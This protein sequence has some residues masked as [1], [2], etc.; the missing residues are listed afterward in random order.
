MKTFCKMWTGKV[1][2]TTM[3]LAFGVCVSGAA[4]A[5]PFTFEFD[6]PDWT[7]A[8]SIA[9][10]GSNPIVDITVD[11]GSSSDLN[12]TYHNS[13]ITQIVVKGNGGSFDGSWAAPNSGG[14]YVY[15]STNASGAAVLDL[16]PAS[17]STEAQFFNSGD[18]LT[19]QLA[20]TSPSGG[21]ESLSILAGDYSIYAFDSPVSPNGGPN[22]GID[23]S[24]QL[25][26]PAGQSGGQQVPEPWSAL[27]IG[28]G[29]AGL[30][31]VR[32]RS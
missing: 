12:Q 32:R 26:P 22:V 8:S 29:L 6:L 10:F 14:N 11:N 18:D 7:A 2:A 1:L 24:G 15:V 21:P 31:V 5:T 9:L 13:Q 25:V 16:A 30:A 20:V 28:I 19:L 17:T 23:V 3:A 27:L 4:S